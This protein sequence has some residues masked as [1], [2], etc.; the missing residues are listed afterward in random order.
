MDAVTVPK[1]LD[2][3]TG[4]LRSFTSV[5]EVPLYISVIAEALG[6]DG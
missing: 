2:C 4:L 1:F 3:C 6:E 5:H